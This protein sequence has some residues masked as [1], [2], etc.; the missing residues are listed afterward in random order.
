MMM[1]R[2][3]KNA[4]ISAKEEQFHGVIYIELPE[5]IECTEARLKE[6]VGFSFFSVYCFDIKKVDECQL[7]HLI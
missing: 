5:I 7:L 3:R 1:M 4:S 6:K 2:K